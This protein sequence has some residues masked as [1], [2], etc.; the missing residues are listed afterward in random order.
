MK[1]ET[2]V[3]AMVRGSIRLMDRVAIETASGHMH[4]VVEVL[5]K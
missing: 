4:P 1:S 2:E 3:V 5:E